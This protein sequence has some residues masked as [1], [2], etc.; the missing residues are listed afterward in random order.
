MGSKGIAIY[1]AVAA[2]YPVT[3]GNSIGGR[4]CSLV[5][6][7]GGGGIGVTSLKSATADIVITTKAMIVTMAT[8]AL[9]VPLGTMLY[10]Y[11]YQ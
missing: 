4:W 6:V 3:I 11:P 10:H 2:A 8:T 9:I 5:G 7:G 1:A